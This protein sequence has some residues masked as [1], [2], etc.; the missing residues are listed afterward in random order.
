MVIDN[1]LAILLPDLDGIESEV[2]LLLDVDSPGRPS[3]RSPGSDGEE[4][5]DLNLGT[6]LSVDG[7]EEPVRQSVRLSQ[8]VFRTAKPSKT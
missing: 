7:T 2:R 6:G 8:A 5:A 1:R 3:T 4:E